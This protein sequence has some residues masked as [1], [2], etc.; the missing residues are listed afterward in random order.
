[1]SLA[2]KNIDYRVIL[3]LEKPFAILLYKSYRKIVNKHSKIMRNIF[4]KLNL[5]KFI[6]NMCNDEDELVRFTTVF[7][8]GKTYLKECGN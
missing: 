5:D 4:F 2:P 1:M 3:L 8:L 6:N 7:D